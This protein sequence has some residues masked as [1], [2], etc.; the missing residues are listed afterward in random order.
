[1]YR[2]MVKQST[3]MA[4]H[5]GRANSAVLKFLILQFKFQLTRILKEREHIGMIQ[6]IT[7]MLRTHAYLDAMSI[8]LL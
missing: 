1:M 5:T 3:H 2:S 7:D 6:T 4:R 8:G